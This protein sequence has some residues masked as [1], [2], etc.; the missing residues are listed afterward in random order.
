MV[1]ISKSLD[2]DLVGRVIEL[3]ESLPHP[4]APLP[5][6]PAR[7]ISTATPLRILA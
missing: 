5:M 7:Q 1:E 2:Y 4:A 3:R 6:H